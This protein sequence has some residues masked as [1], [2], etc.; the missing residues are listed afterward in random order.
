M[1]DVDGFRIDRLEVTNEAFAEFLNIRG[2]VVEDGVAWFDEEDDDARIERVDGRYRSSTGFERYPAVEVT[3]HGARRFCEWRG[4]ALPTAGQW[5]RAA[6]AEDEGGSPWGPHM[7]DMPA[8]NFFHGDAF[9][10]TAPVGSFADGAGPYGT[11]DMAGNVCEWVADD[12][13][14]QR[15]VLG[16]SW[17]ED[18]GSPEGLDIDRWLDAA[19]PNEFTG[20]RCAAPAASPE[21]TS[22]SASR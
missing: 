7:A 5:Y 2:N 6:G 9:P 1:V 14:D 10:Q 16:G 4:A 8:G 3:W 18:P 11:L 21:P 19:H 20:F 22:V 15:L 17:Y 12:N 13:S